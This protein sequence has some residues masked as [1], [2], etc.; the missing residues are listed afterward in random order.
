[1]QKMDSEP[2]RGGAALLTF[3][4][5]WMFAL[6]PLPLVLR[7]F[8]PPFEDSRPAIRVPLFDVLVESVGATP[9][10]GT[11]VRR[12]SIAQTVVYILCWVCIVFALAKP[13]W[14]EPPI[15]KEIPTRDLLLSVDLS[16]SME[17][18]DF[19]SE[20]G[21]K[22]DRLTAT[23]E[24]LDGFL[25]RRQGDR[26]AMIVFGTGPFVQIPFTQDLEVCRELLD[27][28]QVRMAGPK[29]ALGDSIGL[30]IDLFKRSEVTNKVMIVMTDGNDTGS[31]VP[32][33]E[34]AKIAADNGVVIHT[35]GV[36]DPTAAGEELLDEDA[37]KAVAETT[38]GQYFRA[39]DRA[40]LENV[41][42]QIDKLGT[43]PVETISHRPRRD[44]FHLPMA[45]TLVL[46]MLYFIV[47][48]L[49]K[50][51]EEWTI[52]PAADAPEEVAA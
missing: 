30:G 28:T 22:V 47:F 25:K 3:A 44:L 26:V 34:A 14:L 15:T 38:G 36:G 48:G 32:P 46:S 9:S 21:D 17:T 51:F 13:Q 31:K 37:L 24:V 27:E 33:A 18:E 49:G 35:I 39:T 41:Y 45:A 10:T 19:V 7:Y 1:M 50:Y 8:L 16:G 4:H 43:R 29:T 23:K 40:A 20:S 12:R 11:V 42:A 6:I 52:K 2:F 5:I